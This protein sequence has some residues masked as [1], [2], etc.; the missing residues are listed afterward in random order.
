MAF[1]KAAA[2]VEHASLRYL[3]GEPGAPCLGLRALPHRERGLD[4]E[5]FPSRGG[6]LEELGGCGAAYVGDSPGQSLNAILP[7]GEV[8]EKGGGRGVLGKEIIVDRGEVFVDAHA[9]K[10]TAGAVF[11]PF[12]CQWEPDLSF[13]LSA[14]P[15]LKKSFLSRRV[16]NR[17]GPPSGE[18][19]FLP[20]VSGFAQAKLH[21]DE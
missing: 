21:A 2:S 4:T 16:R 6:E 9:G 13:S 14:R 17:L 18:R 5:G 19:F 1:R 15:G 11:S 8:E 7:A 10:Y 20:W 12:P 3:E